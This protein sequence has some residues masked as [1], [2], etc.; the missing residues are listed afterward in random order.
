MPSVK[1]GEALFRRKMGNCTSTFRG[2]FSPNQESG[3]HGLAD[4]VLK[5]VEDEKPSL[6]MDDKN[7]PMIDGVEPSE[8][9][10]NGD[11]TDSKPK[12]D[13]SEV[14]LI[15][16]IVDLCIPSNTVAHH[17][18][19]FHMV[20][21]QNPNLVIRRGSP[22]KL[23]LTMNKAYDAEK[24]ILCMVFTLKGAQSPSYSQ[25]TEIL[26]PIL[27]D[28]DAEKVS[29]VWKVQIL[30]MEDKHITVEVTPAS[31]AIVGE[32]I[33]E[34]DSRLKNDIN[35]A[36]FRYKVTDP[37]IVLFN[38]WCDDDIVYIADDDK[39][40]EYIMADS[41]LVWRGSHNC[42]RPCIWNFAQF[43]ENIL[44]CSLYLLTNVG[45]MGTVTRADPIRVVRHISAVLNCRDDN[46]VIVGNW[47]GKYKGGK[48]PTCWGGSQMILQKYYKTKKP[49]KYG[50]CWVFSGV[51]TTVCRA[52][53]IPARSVTNFSSAHDTHNSLTIDRFFDCHGQP[54]E[55]MN[56]DSVW[57]FHVWTE[58][59]M[60]RP[61][62]E[63][64]DYGGWQAVDSTPQEES[65]G[66]YRCGP[67]SVAAIKRGEVKKAYDATFLFAEVNAD[68]VYWRYHGPNQPLKLIKK[69]T[70][71][72]G[73]CISTKAV[74]KFEREDITDNYKH[75][76]RTKEERE[77]MLRALRQCKN[78]FSRYYLNDDLEDVHF[79]FTLLDDI[80]IGSPFTLR[81][82]AVNKR[83][84]GDEYTV[85]ISLRVDSALYTGQSK[86]LVKKDE[87][88]IQLGPGVEQEMTMALKYEEYERSLSDQCG[89]II[90]ATAHVEETGFD[91]C[92]QDDFRV[93]MP[94][95]S[96]QVNG[97][98]MQNRPMT[99]IA[100]LTNPLPKPLKKG[101]FIIE[102]P[103]LGKPLRLK[104]SGTIAPGADAKV[105]C[106][107]TP[108][109]SGAKTVIAKFRSNELED[110]DGYHEIYV[111]PSTEGEK[112][113]K[114][115]NSHL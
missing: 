30:E 67:A 42:L 110:V 89:F 108:K 56:I 51:F 36:D 84:E 68:K 64:G 59:W 48:S 109:T 113:E 65:D 101:E 73:Q 44:D 21:K 93:R 27:I 16:E 33:L 24:D 79:E 4:I 87:F 10:T 86:K 47:S 7:L 19:V 5:P 34:V 40:E 95:I 52:L 74:G 100:T 13:D 50:Q 66:L 45:R 35:A 39:R 90:S 114:E 58:V 43:E 78:A 83:E 41:G 70:E 112:G 72:I 98:I 62:L 115:N 75:V 25:N 91:F 57:N 3:N 26:L 37:I 29:T 77:V 55:K 96:I 92:E 6:T 23:D 97:E 20:Q 53:G 102:G 106:S 22:F 103:G 9:I 28:E 38:P 32:W 85:F 69:S 14:P 105:T 15:V 104:C 31:N 46:G 82:K 49:I 81:L 63:P 54:L 17:T 18:N 107:M 12:L 88:E 61:D 11:R 76:E 80:V 111:K 1:E 71:E 99:V 2:K 60:Q 8:P 94:D